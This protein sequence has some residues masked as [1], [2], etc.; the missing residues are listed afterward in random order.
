[1]RAYVGCSGWFYW[2][3]RG[4]FY[5]DSKRTDAWFKHYATEFETV[6]LNAP[7]YKWPKPATIKAWKRNAPSDFRYSVKVNQL[8]THEKRCRRTDRLVREFYQIADILG[9]Q[10]GCFLFQ[11]PPSYKY[12]ASRLRSILRQLDP[13]YRN[14]VEFRHKS[15]WRPTVFRQFRDAGL[16]FCSVDGPRLP[17]ELVE[18][19]DT[20]YLRFHGRTRW[21]RHDYSHEELLS[22][23][24]KVR[25]SR[26]RE[27]WIYFN[28]DR[29]GFAIRNAQEMRRMFLSSKLKS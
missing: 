16:I 1:M 9:P 26:A 27:V 15:W 12:T 5:P 20:I 19:G 22:W 18:T 24:K 6:E 8:I 23:A 21:Y 4:I 10:M 3:W 29:E 17:N 14:A 11:F 28:N 25:A 2:H 13:A 7:F